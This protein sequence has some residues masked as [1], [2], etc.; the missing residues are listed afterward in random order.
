[1]QFENSCRSLDSAV[2]GVGGAQIFDAF[3]AFRRH[4][5]LSFCSSSIDTSMEMLMKRM[6]KAVFGAAAGV[7]FCHSV[8]AATEVLPVKNA[9]QEPLLGLYP[10]KNFRMADGDC[11]DCQGT[12]KQSLWYFRDQPI[13][14]PKENVSGFSRKMR[15]QEDI[16]NWY[17]ETQKKGDGSLPGLLWIGAPSVLEGRF[18]IDGKSIAT[19]E[20]MI[21]PLSL[22]PQLESNRSYFNEDSQQFFSGRMVRARGHQAEAGFVART[23]WPMD[24]ALQSSQMPL[25]PLSVGE[26]ISDLVRADDTK[27]TEQLYSRLL[28]SRSGQALKLEGRPVMAFV[29][30]GAQGD[31]DEAHGGHF[32]IATGYFGPN[33]EW[34]NWLVNNFY[35]LGSVSEK[36][37]V[38]SILPMDAYQADLNSG[39]SWY[40]PSYMLVAV[41][42]DNRTPRIYQEAINRAFN[43]FY[44]HDFEYNHATANCAGINME[45]LRSLGWN[46]PLQGPDSRLKA[47]AAL[48]YMAIK[49]GSLDSGRKAFEYLSSEKTNLYPF[50]AFEA[51]G[52]DLLQRL[53]GGQRLE[54]DYEKMLRE[55]LEGIVFVRIPQFPSSRATGMAPVASLDEYMNRTPPNR[56]DWK[57]IPVP[58]RPFPAALKDPE[59]P[60][61]AISSSNLAL[62]AYGGVLSILSVGGWQLKRRRQDVSGKGKQS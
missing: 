11:Q 16:R 45:A 27:F 34:D 17:A 37:I 61:E 60:T 10:A 25:R 51:A 7:L 8:L 3:G 48:P 33:G 38:A 56:A 5:H 32:A 4:A 18:S 13:A 1:M 43:H 6:S 59:A 42:R 19:A 28:W 30:N 15:V 29:L 49:D 53:I 23:L 62:M 26:R 21:Q 9:L 50:V 40:R 35:G 41:F 22:V 12:P 57:V 20:S 36:G 54:S 2:A 31:D 58:P 39:Q 52:A 47:A 24:F 44:R 14:V 46:I 55:D